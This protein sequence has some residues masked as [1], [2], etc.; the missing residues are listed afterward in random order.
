MEGFIVFLSGQVFVGSLKGLRVGGW[1]PINPFTERI[2]KPVRKIGP[3]LRPLSIDSLNGG[4]TDAL[5]KAPL[6]KKIGKDYNVISLLLLGLHT[7]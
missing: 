7:D 4:S 3:P 2:E 6:E 1:G 5:K